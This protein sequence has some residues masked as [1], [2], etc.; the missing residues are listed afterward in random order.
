MD[1][2]VAL[3]QVLLDEVAGAV[4]EVD[5][6]AGAA[7]H[8]V[9]AALAVQRVVAGIA[10]QRVGIGAA[11]RV[12]VAAAIEDH[13]FDIGADGVVDR[14][15]DDIVALAGVLLDE[16]A[17][18]VDDI[19][20]VAGTADHGVM[21]GVTVERVVA[22]LAA[23]EVRLAVAGAI[24]IAGSVQDQRVGIGGQRIADGGMDDVVALAGIL[25]DHVAGVVDDID[26]VAGSARHRV[27]PGAAVERVVAGS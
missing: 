24:D 20:V 27:G 15:M 21:A 13:G 3:A 8:D 7:H 18:A 9:V 23:E 17:G 26:V 16:I 10:D 2:V 4:D 11:G 5:V 22:G 25:R 6:V 12:D 14:G 1:D 19:D